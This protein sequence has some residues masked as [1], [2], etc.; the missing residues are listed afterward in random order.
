MPAA[1]G[2]L[3]LLCGGILGARLLPYLVASPAPVSTKPAASALTSHVTGAT[4]SGGAVPT[5]PA[6]A[7]RPGSHWIGSF[8][9]RPPI[10]NYSGSLALTVL[11]RSGDTFEA[12][13]SSEN[14]AYEWRVTG[15]IRGENARWEFLKATKNISKDDAAGK[16]YVEATVAGDHITGAFRMFNNPNEVA[17]ITLQLDK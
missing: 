4:A 2:L 3:V 5:D 14:G 16:A 8:H 11:R 6:S 7:L 13:Y 1:V 17:D 10:R 15:A 12:L 9:F